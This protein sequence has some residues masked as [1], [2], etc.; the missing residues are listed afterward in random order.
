MLTYLLEVTVCWTVCYLLYYLLLSRETFFWLNR[1][2]LMF[3]L[4]L[5]MVIPLIEFSGVEEQAVVQQMMWYMEPITVSIS[6]AGNTLDEI[7][8]IGTTQEATFLSIDEIVKWIYL[9]GALV[10][11]ILLLAGLRKIILLKKRS[12]VEIKEDHQFILTDIFHL[13][14]SF[15]DNLFWSKKIEFSPADRKAILNHE[16]AHIKQHHSLDLMIVEV[17]GILFWFHP[18]VYCYKKSI[19]NVHEYLA[20]SAAMTT[21]RRKQYGQLLVRQ[22]QP[23]TQPSLANHFIHSQ[24]KKRIIMITKNKSRN[25]KLLKYALALPA[26]AILFMAFSYS[27]LY[28]NKNTTDTNIEN[29]V[30]TDPS[31]T[32]IFQVVEEM[33]YYKGCEDQ[34][35]IKVELIKCAQEK[36][37]EHVYKNIRY[38][39]I[40]REAGVE[41]M[42]VIRFIVDKNGKV[43]KPEIVRNIGAGCGEEALKVVSS[44]GD[45]NPGKQRGKKVSVYYNL[46]VKFKL[47]HKENNDKDITLKYGENEPLF[48]ING[49]KYRGDIEKK[50]SPD[51]IE[52]IEVLKGEKAIEKYGEDGKNGVVEIVVIGYSNKAKVNK[53]VF[54]GE[55]ILKKPAQM[56]RFPG[57]ENQELASEE[58]EM[59][60]KRKL[61]EFIYTNVKYPEVARKNDIQGT[62]V[63]RF[64]VDK[65]G[66]VQ[67][68]EIVRDVGGG[69]GA[70]V[71]RVTNLMS[72]QNIQWTPGR[73]SEGKTANVFFNLPV[74]FKLDDSKDKN[75]DKD[76]NKAK[77]KTKEKV[78]IKA[79][80]Q[81][82]ALKQ[83]SSFPN[84]ATDQITV[85]F[86]GAAKPVSIDLLNMEGKLIQNEQ[87]NDFDGNY[88]RS[89]DVKDLAPGTY[90]VRI[91]QGEQFI[92]EKIIIE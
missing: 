28:S 63:V 84:P 46:P 79:S 37:L 22:V 33:P 27:S 85:Q 71:L 30:L 49:E 8:V 67:E 1:W 11:F 64:I 25:A 20:D 26:L 75:K 4:L 73:T 40:A 6:Q 41:G 82:L 60:S 55:K 58:L 59:C 5:G 51:D 38:P 48:V 32:T 87:I 78:K 2:Y 70:E 15:F 24:L 17:V 80:T 45:W 42:V 9:A 54:N 66:N 83:F 13:P 39:K 7:V 68:P 89:F 14:F 52:S 12:N 88:N 19:R 90:L 50:I 69:T 62:C 35:L 74:K 10:A 61:L 47:D 3:T 86:S 57:C 34:E 81:K 21:T 76:K 72:E 23:D 16:L 29:N 36:M 65:N 77:D 91:T 53:S 18:L 92:T 56:P 43:K 44:L 31:D